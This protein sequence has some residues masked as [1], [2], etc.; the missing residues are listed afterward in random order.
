[1]LWF[2][3]DLVVLRLWHWCLH[4]DP[5]PRQCETVKPL[6]QLGRFR[7]VL[8]H[9]AKHDDTDQRYPGES[10]GDDDRRIRGPSPCDDPRVAGDDSPGGGMGGYRQPGNP[11]EIGFHIP[12]HAVGVERAVLAVIREAGRE[13]AIVLRRVELPRRGI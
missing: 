12:P 6:Q 4:L 7:H 10:V 9:L 2:V 13:P 5:P 11:V 8:D 1:M 3:Q